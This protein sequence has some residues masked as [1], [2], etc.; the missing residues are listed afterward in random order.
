MIGI[1]TSN[2]KLVRP[3]DKSKKEIELYD[4]EKD[5][6]EEN[7]ISSENIQKSNSLEDILY[8]IRSD[9]EETSTTMLGKNEEAKL[10][11]QELRKLGYL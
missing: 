4:L 7:N 3:L 9:D 1:R 6:L 11:E 2:Y 5:P 10:V 8:E